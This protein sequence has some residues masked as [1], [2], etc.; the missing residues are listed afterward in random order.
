MIEGSS[1]FM[2]YHYLP[3]FEGHRSCTS[4][5]MF[6]VCQMIKQDHVIKGSGDYKD[7]NPSRSVTTLP[8]L[9]VIGTVVMNI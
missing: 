4:R 5:D 7:R 9:V 2:V 3:K 6:L 8:R 1:N